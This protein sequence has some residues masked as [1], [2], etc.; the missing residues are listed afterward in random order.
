MRMLK[1]ADPEDRAH[2]EVMAVRVDGDNLLCGSLGG[3]KF[4][5]RGSDEPHT[6]ICHPGTLSCE[7]EIE[8]KLCR[9]VPPPLNTSCQYECACPVNTGGCRTGMLLWDRRQQTSDAAD[10][11]ICEVILT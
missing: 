7:M 10:S 3:L 8:M 11:S 5:A 6:D 1:F 4:Y 9:V 2:P